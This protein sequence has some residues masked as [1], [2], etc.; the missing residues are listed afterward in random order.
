MDQ[1]DRAQQLD[2]MH[3]DIALAEHQRRTRPGAALSHCEDC[4]DPIPPER[5]AR[6]PGVRR[7]IDCQRDHELAQRTGAR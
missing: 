4:A 2:E 1:F 3:R 5:A 7:C 6:V